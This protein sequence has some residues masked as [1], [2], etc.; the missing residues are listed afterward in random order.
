MEDWPEGAHERHLAGY[1]RSSVQ[2][3]CANPQ[4]PV[5]EDGMDVELECEYGQ[6]VYQPEECPQCSGEWLDEKP[7][8]ADE[9]EPD[10]VEWRN[11]AADDEHGRWEP[12]T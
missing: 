3:W 12:W 5:H 8:P 1:S 2:V 4:C 7:E 11:A 6:C 10:S 9:A